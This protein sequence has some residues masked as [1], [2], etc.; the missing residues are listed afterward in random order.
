MATVA[1][2]ARDKWRMPSPGK[3]GGGREEGTEEDEVGQAM[4]ETGRESRNMKTGHELAHFRTALEGYGF[5]ERFTEVRL[6][7]EN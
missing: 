4:K 5:T 3:R 2:S 6:R 7:T 1:R